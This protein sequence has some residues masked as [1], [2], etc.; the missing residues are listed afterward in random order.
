MRGNPQIIAELNKLLKNELTAINQYFLHARMM[1]H[2]GF[3]RL[4]KKIYDE[5]IGEMK[6]ADRLIQRIL[7][8][9]GLPNLQDLGRLG[10]G[11]TVPECLNA[12]LRLESAARTDVVAAVAAC[13]AAQ[14]YVSREIA[15]DILDDAE[16]HIDF[17]ET[18]LALLEKV[19][20]QNY[21]QTQIG[22]GKE[23]D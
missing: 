17:L 3:E 19:G 21:L 15:V 2:W 8:L 20:E 12:D 11:E 5:S 22:E 13:E 10:I 14:D 9:E 7:L 18:E 23:P 6:H 16:S 1:K 4:G